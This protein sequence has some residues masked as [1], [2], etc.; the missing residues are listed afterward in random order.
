MYLVYHK[1]LTKCLHGFTL[2]EVN[3]RKGEHNGNG[4]GGASL[5]LKSQQKRLRRG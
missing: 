5:P 2:S 1:C 4:E 3:R